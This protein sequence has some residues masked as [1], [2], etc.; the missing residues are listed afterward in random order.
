MKLTSLSEIDESKEFWRGTR[1]RLMNHGD[2]HPDDKYFDYQLTELPGDTD[3]MILVNITED[4]HKAGAVYFGLVPIIEESNKRV[5]NIKTL[6]R[7][8]DQDFEH[9]YLME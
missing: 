2:M 9:C 8:F 6:E 1:I 5:I 3:H 7:V 4:S